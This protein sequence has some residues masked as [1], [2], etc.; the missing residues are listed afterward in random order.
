[1][2]Q[3]Q[4]FLKA[5]SWHFSYLIFSRLLF[6]NFILCKIALD[7]A[8]C[9]HNFMKKFHSKLSKMKLNISH[10]LRFI[11]L[12]VKRFKRLKIDF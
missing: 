3:G 6:L 10:K 8:M 2:I 7:V 11:C 1:M 5:G 4:V 9:Y 12:F